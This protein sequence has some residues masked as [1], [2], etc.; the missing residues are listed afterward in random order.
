MINASPSASYDRG[1]SLP[2]GSK[3]FGTWFDRR[4]AKSALTAPITKINSINSL[5]N[6]KIARKTQYN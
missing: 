2:L 1:R 5:T 6:S 3:R 4:P